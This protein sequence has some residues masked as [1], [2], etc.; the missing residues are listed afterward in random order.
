MGARS[1]SNTEGNFGSLQAPLQSALVQ[2]ELCS[3]HVVNSP[4]SKYTDELFEIRSGIR[5][6]VHK[7]PG[8]K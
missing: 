2:G 5:R 4:Q 7:Y 6:Q 3:N 8:E 1:D